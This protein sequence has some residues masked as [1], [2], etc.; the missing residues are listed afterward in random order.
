MRILIELF[1]EIFSCCSYLNS[2]VPF[3]LI[4]LNI[5]RPLKDLPRLI[6]IP[7]HFQIKFFKPT[8]KL[9]EK[10]VTTSSDA[11]KNVNAENILQS[12]RSSEEKII[13]LGKSLI[14]KSVVDNLKT[15]KFDAGDMKLLR[16]CSEPDLA[17]FL[18]KATSKGEVVVAGMKSDAAVILK[19]ADSLTAI[20]D[21][22][23]ASLRCR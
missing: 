22:S 15:G 14:Q 5:I 8:E 4:S 12:N 1:I 3:V 2:K 11:S 10:K 18:C 6:F 19:K 9:F 16:T 23:E 21:I 7:L 20:D 17:T 13:Q